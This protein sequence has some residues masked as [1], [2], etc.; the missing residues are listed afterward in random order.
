MFVGSSGRGHGPQNQLH[1]TADTPKL[2]QIIQETIPNHFWKILSLEISKF[3]E[4]EISKCWN[5]RGPGNTKDPSDKFLKILHLGSIPSRKH[6]MEI[7][8]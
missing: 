4:S 8:N 2:F 1:S 7:W 6:E 5:R 3:C